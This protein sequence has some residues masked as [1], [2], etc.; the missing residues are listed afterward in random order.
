MLFCFSVSHKNANLPVLEAINIRNENEFVHD[1]CSEGIVKECVI[2]QT[3]HRVE[4]YCT[5]PSQ[6]KDNAIKQ[7]QKVWSTTA[8]VSL[9]IISKFA[10]IYCEREAIEHLFFLASGLESMILG[11]AQILGQV[12]TAFLAAKKRGTSGSLLDQVFMK[13][14]NVGKRIRTETKIN[15]G[16]VSVSSAA[17]DLAENE[18]GDLTS[19]KVLII[20]AGEAGSLAAEALRGH[21]VS[22]ITVANRTLSKSQV[23]AEKVSGVA[24]P[25]SDV[26]AA[27]SRA[28][29]VIAAVSVKEP[30]LTEK[31]LSSYMVNSLESKQTLMV[32]ISQPRAIEEN[33]TSFPGVRL[34]TIDDL[35]QII[36]WNLK[37]RAAEAEKS[38]VMISDELN[39]F[40]LELSKLAAQPIINGIC[41]SFEE[42]R[43]REL[44]RAIRKMHESD[45]RKLAV[46]E[47]FSKELIERVAQI[48]VTQL[49]KAALNGDETVLSTAEQLFQIKSENRSLNA[50]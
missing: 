49:K 16:S 31:Q 44:A 34:K 33:V 39:R 20:G 14:I 22:A 25:F 27:I 45:E 28:D 5:I 48:P 47:R 13:A 29:L 43:Q 9:D 23:L 3:C 46:L 35:N 12:R 42:I 21:S 26:F 50:A 36:A 38:K 2:L 30:L 40:E 10:K 8:G 32:D 4:I 7:V 11:E 19:K 41:R 24:I 6:D 1:L 37:N 15:V 18:L 17:V